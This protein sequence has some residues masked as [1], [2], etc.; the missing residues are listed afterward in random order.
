M[1]P[2]PGFPYLRTNRFLTSLRERLETREAEEEWI[3]WMQ[4]LDLEAREK[5]IRNLPEDDFASVTERSVTARDPVRDRMAFCSDE[6]LQNDQSRAG[7]FTAVRAAA[8][9][10]DEYSLFLR[11]AGLYPIAALPVIALTQR[12]R[13]KFTDWFE[14]DLDALPLDGNVIAYAP[15]PSPPLGKSLRR[16]FKDLGRGSLMV[17]RLSEDQEKELASL[18]APVFFQDVAATYDRPGRVVWKDGEVNID[19]RAPTVYHYLSHAFFQGEPVLQLN[20]VWWYSGRS[21]PNSPWIERGHLDGLT[22]R[23]T[24]DPAGDPFMADLMNNCGCY[25]LFAPA[26]E[27]TVRRVPKTLGLD[28]FAPQQL[29][30]T[31]PGARLGVR[32]SSGWHQVQRLFAREMPPDAIRYQL[33]PYDILE[34]LPRE[35]GRTESI[36]DSRGIVKGTQRIEPLLLFPM[37]VPR[38]GSMRQRGHHAVE[39]VGRAHFDDPD[40]FDTRFDFR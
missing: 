36:F 15:P 5:E 35:N 27:R 39:L 34:M 23:I 22:L 25:H 6:L 7:F 24:F 9:V 26:R 11:I 4:E 20:Y 2:V 18:L 31:F 37:G 16:W 21:G 33:V 30:E 40:F 8:S 13:G 17:P 12:K 10:P 28:P 14:S 3:R 29:P 19:P 32:V 1:A 38:V